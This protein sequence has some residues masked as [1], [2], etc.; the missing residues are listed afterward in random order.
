M[1][2]HLILF[3]LILRPRY[4]VNAAHVAAGPLNS[5]QRLS[6]LWATRSHLNDGKI[7][8][9]RV[10]PHKSSILFSSEISLFLPM[11]FQH[12]YEIAFVPVPVPDKTA[13]NNFT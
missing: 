12:K 6:A 13:A 8:S 11:G 1:H 10:L 3:L 7:V 2:L 5:L 9:Y 4:D